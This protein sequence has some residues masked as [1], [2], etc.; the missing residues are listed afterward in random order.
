[1]TVASWRSL[2]ALVVTAG[3]LA[4]PSAARACSV[5]F[6]GD[7]AEAATFILTT[8]LLT[9]TPFLVVGAIGFWV[10]KRI[11][12]TES[13]AAETHVADVPAASAAEHV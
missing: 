1:M 5:C 13:E 3:V 6:G 10:V 11:R 9:F 7:G 2:A 12:Q 8:A 4:W